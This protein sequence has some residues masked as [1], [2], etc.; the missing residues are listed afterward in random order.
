MFE[1]KIEELTRTNDKCSQYIAKREHE[2]RQREKQSFHLQQ[3]DET[4][5]K[6]NDEIHRLYDQVYIST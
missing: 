1:Q 5:R 3:F 6:Y 4:K 2:H